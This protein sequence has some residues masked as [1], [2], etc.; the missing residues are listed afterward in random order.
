VAVELSSGLSHGKIVQIVAASSDS[1][2]WPKIDAQG[3]YLV[4]GLIDV[5]IHLQTP[6]RGVLA[7]FDFMWLVESIFA[8]YAP[9]RR[10]RSNARFRRSTSWWLSARSWAA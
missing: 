6:L 7:D 2:G 8:D 4:P 10:I 5:H 3:S 1:G 9:G